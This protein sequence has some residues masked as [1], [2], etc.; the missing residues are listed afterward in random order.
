MKKRRAFTAKKSFVDIR[1]VKQTEPESCGLNCIT[2]H[3]TGDR[4]NP[5]TNIEMFV[6]NGK[7]ISRLLAFY[8]IANPFFGIIVI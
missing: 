6:L 3:V 8:P 5:T 4:Y 2:R 7:K 1:L